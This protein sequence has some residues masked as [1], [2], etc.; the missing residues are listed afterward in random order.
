[1]TSEISAVRKVTKN[2]AGHGHGFISRRKPE[3]VVRI[4]LENINSVG[5]SNKKRAKNSKPVLISNM[6]DDFEVDVM[7]HVEPQKN[8]DLV[9]DNLQYN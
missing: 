8:W 4:T 7:C 1:M 9:D 3:G 6:G 2:W 5:V